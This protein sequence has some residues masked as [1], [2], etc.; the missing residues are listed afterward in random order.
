MRRLL[1]F[2]FLLLSV[3]GF[4]QHQYTV[5]LT[6]QP[7]T[8][9]AT[10]SCSDAVANYDVF[11]MGSGGTFE[12]IASSVTPTTYSDTGVQWSA[13]Y[14]YYVTSVDAQGNQSAPSNTVSVTI[15]SLILNP[16]TGVIL[17]IA[18]M[19]TGLEH[20]HYQNQCTPYDTL[21][22]PG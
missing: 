22:W 19:R 15:P 3:P 11:R 4:A 1:L 21:V 5:L 16:A 9:M 18:D 12:Q 7:P 2:L 8:C 13:T 6:W 14:Q 10:N 17:I 20:I